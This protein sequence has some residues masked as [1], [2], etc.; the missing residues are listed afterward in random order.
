MA[1][2]S[3]PVYRCADGTIRHSM[4]LYRAINPPP[5]GPAQGGG[6]PSDRTD[7]RLL[8]GNMPANSSRLGA[9]PGAL[10]GAR[11]ELSSP[12]LRTE[13]A[14][15]SGRPQDAVNDGHC[16]ARDYYATAVQFD[17]NET[18][19]GG[20]LKALK[21]PGNALQPMIPALARSEA[22]G[23]ATTRTLG[24]SPIGAFRLSPS[25]PYPGQR[26]PHALTEDAR[27]D[28]GDGG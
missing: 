10:P 1:G 18:G 15:I 6:R 5:E 4:L 2:R 17:A 3:P 25:S 20:G 27:D 7:I 16:M 11:S 22:R 23:R 13:L 14:G 8:P 19:P 12:E 24:P 28:E 21:G 26:G 9:P